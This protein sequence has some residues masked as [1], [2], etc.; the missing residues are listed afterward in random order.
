MVDIYCR[1]LLEMLNQMQQFYIAL[2]TKQSL[3]LE[4]QEFQLLVF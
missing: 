3:N 1:F 4:M 2:S